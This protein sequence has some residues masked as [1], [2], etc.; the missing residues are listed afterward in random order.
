MKIVL[1]FLLSLLPVQDG[2]TAGRAGDYHIGN[3]W[4][5]FGTDRGSAMG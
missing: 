1:A 2:I 3:G 4:S 5:E